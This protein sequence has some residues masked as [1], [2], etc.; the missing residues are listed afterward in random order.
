V[1]EEGSDQLGPIG[2]GYTYSGHALGTAAALANLDIIE[3]E[4]LTG[5]A[6]NTGA[7]FQTRM[8]ETFDHHPLV[9]EVRGIGLL[10]ALE[11]V[12]DKETRQRFEPVLKVGPRVSMACL[13]NG[14]I[15]RAM[16]HGDILGFAPPL[17][18]SK[19]EVDEVVER[20]RR[21]VDAVTDA[22]MRERETWAT[23]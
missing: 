7:Y 6:R 16:P 18:I 22:L 10:A 14:L 17:V 5:N 9:G 1:L 20:T 8:H 21:A 3:K 19:E 4:D 2:H 23:P 11:F 12:A 15:A 13:E